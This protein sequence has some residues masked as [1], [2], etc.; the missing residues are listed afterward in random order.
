MANRKDMEELI[1][2]CVIVGPINTELLFQGKELFAEQVRHLTVV[3]HQSLQ[4]LQGFQLNIYQIFWIS[5]NINK[6]EIQLSLIT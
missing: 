2:V 1:C 5:L 6:I 4:D 3:L